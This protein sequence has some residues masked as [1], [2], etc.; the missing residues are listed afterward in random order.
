MQDDINVQ[1]ERLTAK[2]KR[3][4]QEEIFEFKSENNNLRQSVEMLAMENDRLSR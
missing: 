1:V 2:F 4:L 3:E